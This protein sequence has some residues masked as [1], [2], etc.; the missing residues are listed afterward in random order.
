MLPSVILER[1]FGSDHLYGGTA[2]QIPL[3]VPQPLTLT[4]MGHVSCAQQSL[5]VSWAHHDQCIFQLLNFDMLLKLLETRAV[6]HSWL[7][8]SPSVKGSLKPR[9]GHSEVRHPALPLAPDS[10]KPDFLSYS[11]N[12]LF[13]KKFLTTPCG[14][15]DLSALTGD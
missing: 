13:L 1:T 7:F 11:S 3:F 14:M 2:P 15:L 12:L 9:V 8:R 5:S 10:K 6:S 4:V